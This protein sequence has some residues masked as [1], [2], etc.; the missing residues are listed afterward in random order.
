MVEV[1]IDD[2]EKDKER[3]NA[4]IKYYGDTRTS[5]QRLET[6]D[7]IIHQDNDISIAFEIKTWQD[8]IGS[9]KKRRVQ[10]E[11][12]KMKKIYPFSFLIIY[13]NGKWNKKYTHA[14][15]A[16]IQGNIISIMQ[17]YKVPVVIA[18]DL[19]ELIVCLD[20]CVKNVNKSLEPIEPPVVRPKDSNEM[21]NV[22]IGLP[23]VGKKTARKLLDEFNKPSNV[24]NAT[25]DELDNI[26][27]LT[28]VSKRAIL[29]M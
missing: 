15:R 18:K 7:I 21:I 9:I 16:Q 14:S 1:I 29:R 2:R 24:F 8:F 10:E 25:E 6:G 12:L 19:N 20:I 5:I 23:K 26:K 27:G 17:R 13:D 11:C 3:V 22:L 28:K 4:I